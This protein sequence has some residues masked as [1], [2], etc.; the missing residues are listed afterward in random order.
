MYIF[1]LIQKIKIEI[2]S[3]NFYKYYGGCT[4]M[5]QNVECLAENKIGIS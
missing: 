1:F 4:L 3:F 2:R 5:T